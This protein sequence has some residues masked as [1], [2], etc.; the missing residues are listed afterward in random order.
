MTRV[1]YQSRSEAAADPF[2]AR[3]MTAPAA[4]V[5]PS[6]VLTAGGIRLEIDGAVASVV[7]DRADR[8]NAMTPAMWLALAAVPDLLPEST[9]VVVVRGDGAS[10]CAGLDLRLATPEGVPGEGT[11]ADFFGEHVDDA[12]IADTIGEWQRGFTWLRDPRWITIS[13]VQGA[14]VG[15]GFQLALSTDLCLAAEDAKFCMRENALGLIPDMT[16]TKALFDRVG[17]ARALEICATARWVP[18]AE[19]AQLGIVQSVV[20]AAGLETVVGELV[21]A[22]LANPAPPAVA[23]KRLLLDAGPRDV[24]TQAR[25]EREI[26]VPMLRTMAARIKG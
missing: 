19:A 20:P 2:Y 22:L 14:A 10:F 13:A 26:Q 9:R 1:T 15:A 16:G 6:D 24:E 21:A 8:R 25:A 11:F 4:T 18:A 5:I 12:G 17:Y 23:L 3:R 7:L